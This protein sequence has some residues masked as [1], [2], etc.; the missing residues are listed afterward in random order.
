MP[1]KKQVLLK[2]Q[3]DLQELNASFENEIQVIERARLKKFR[4][5]EASRAQV[6]EA[7]TKTSEAGAERTA[8]RG[9]ATAA[10]DKAIADATL[11]RRAGLVASEKAWRKA[12]DEAQRERDDER[13][14]ENRKH[15][16]R[17]EEIDA[18]LPMYR[19]AAPREAENARHD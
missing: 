13:T 19:Q 5:M 10:R 15:V 2:F 4:S 6:A 9:R 12:E 3:K 17:M 1:T 8:D 18:I 11:K 7:D 16:D 14:E